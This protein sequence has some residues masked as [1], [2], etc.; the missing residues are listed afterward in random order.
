MYILALCEGCQL[1]FTVERHSMTFHCHYLIVSQ[2]IVSF[3]LNADD[4]A[5]DGLQIEVETTQ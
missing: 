3:G 5:T 4:L 1:S 2:H